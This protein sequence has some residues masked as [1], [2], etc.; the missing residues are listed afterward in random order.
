MSI[1]F[2]EKNGNLMESSISNVEL[3]FVS[4]TGELYKSTDEES[5]LYSKDNYSSSLIQFKASFK[6]ILKD[7][8]NPRK[9]KYC[10]TCKKDRIIVMIYIKNN[11][12][13]TCEKCKKS[14]FEGDKFD[15]L[16]S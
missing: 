8:T 4:N 15:D 11:L 16:L 7:R 3:K 6:N 14:W 13:N 10:F 2:D 1:K 12:I 5:L 9:K